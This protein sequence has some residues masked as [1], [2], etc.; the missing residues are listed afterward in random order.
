MSHIVSVGRISDKHL[1]GCRYCA[2]LA[3]ALAAAAAA[4]LWNVMRQRRGWT[5]SALRRRAEPYIR[6]ALV[7][8]KVPWLPSS[9]AREGR[10]VTVA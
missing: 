5:P 3:L 9:E 8:C 6:R 2:L 7:G 10:V 4:L 1:P